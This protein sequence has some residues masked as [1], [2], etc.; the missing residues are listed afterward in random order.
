MHR[1]LFSIAGA[2]MIILGV[3]HIAPVTVAY[4]GDTAAAVTTADPE[5]KVEG[6]A[7]VSVPDVSVKTGDSDGAW[8]LSPIWIVV[9]LLAIGVLIAIVAAA[10]RGGGTTVVK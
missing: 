3:L 4:A 7:K 6:S 1:A 5:S 8:Y 2:L 10:T 9:G